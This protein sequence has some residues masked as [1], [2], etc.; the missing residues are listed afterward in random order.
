[1]KKSARRILTLVLTLVL[2]CTLAA[3]ALAVDDEYQVSAVS[4]STDC[5]DVYFRTFV[6]GD[7]TCA[8]AKMVVENPGEGSFDAT[9]ILDYTYCPDNQMRPSAYLTGTKTH[10]FTR[11]TGVKHTD[12]TLGSSYTMIE[13]T[14]HLVVEKSVGKTTYTTEGAY[15]TIYINS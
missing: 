12:H 11:Y 7:G 10:S 15:A 3:I 8:I 13:A 6:G 5:H 14:G 1:M 4:E 9:V 2:V